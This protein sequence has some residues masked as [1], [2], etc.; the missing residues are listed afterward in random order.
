VSSTKLSFEFFPPRDE[1]AL[2]KLVATRKRLDA[3]DPQY[4]SVTFGAG[5]STRHG[6]LNT[7]VGLRQEASAEVAPHISCV[8]LEASEIDELLKT[9]RSLGIKRIVALRG[10]LGSGYGALGDFNNAIELVRHIRETSG[11]HFHIEVAC[12][13]EFHPEATSASADLIYF[14]DKVAAGADGAIT[15]Y[16]FNPDAYFRFVEAVNKLGV[17]IPI[18]PGIMPITNYQQLSRFSAMCGAEIPRWLE[19]RMRELANDKDGLFQLGADFI[20]DMC[21]RLIDGGA[22]GLHIYTLNRSESTLAICDRL[23][24]NQLNEEAATQPHVAQA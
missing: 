16:F 9:Y 11:D 18:V 19:W 5:G 14:R 22:P 21:Q 20:G 8:G 17:D 12:Y 15:Q 6:T 24:V 4:Y 2:E 23:G 3:L 10:D 1:Q 13:P 7:V